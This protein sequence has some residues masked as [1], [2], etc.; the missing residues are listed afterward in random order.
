M[1]CAK[2]ELP[3][4]PLNLLQKDAMT[5]ILTTVM[6]AVIY[7]SSNAAM[8]LQSVVKAAIT[9][10]RALILPVS[11]FLA[12][13]MFRA[14]QVHRA[15]LKAVMVAIISANLSAA[16]EFQSATSSAMAAHVK[17]APVSRTV[18]VLRARK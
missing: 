17:M 9:A 18:L 1:L 16:M 8:K 14:T 13:I 15:L 12:Q 3:M 7:A 11:Q 2:V 10:V 6:A 5:E 4:A